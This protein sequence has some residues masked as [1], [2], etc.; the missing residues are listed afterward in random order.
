MKKIIPFLFFLSLPFCSRSCPIDTISYWKVYHNN[1][2]LKN[3]NDYTN[4][5]I[6]IKSKNYKPGDYLAIQY[7]DDTPCE[8]CKFA[9]IVRGEGKSEIYR[10]EF[11]GENKLIKINL[12]NLIDFRPKT[13]PSTFIIYLY[14]LEDKNKKNGQ[15]LI[16]VKIE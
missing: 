5:S 7:F 13:N 6:V 8:D 10:S 3:L 11:K 1:V 2:L 9:L 12:K 4:N 14:E 15:R 16:T